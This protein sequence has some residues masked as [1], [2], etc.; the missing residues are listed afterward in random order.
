MGIH[1]LETGL[2]PLEI[3]MPCLPTVYAP[4]RYSTVTKVRSRSLWTWGN[5]DNFRITGSISKIRVCIFFGPDRT[6]PTDRDMRTT[7]TLNTLR[8]R[9]NRVGPI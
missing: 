2:S 8:I 9:I 5:R 6:G 4:P 1:L 7:Y 3:D